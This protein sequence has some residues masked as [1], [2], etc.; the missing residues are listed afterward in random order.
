MSLIHNVRAQYTQSTRFPVIAGLENAIWIPFKN[1]TF[2]L[3][4]PWPL[5][6]T[7]L[8]LNH[9][10]LLL[11]KLGWIADFYVGRSAKKRKTRERSRAESTE[12]EAG[13]AIQIPGSMG[14]QGIEFQVAPDGKEQSQGCF[15]VWTNYEFLSIGVYTTC[16]T[17][18]E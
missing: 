11:Q 17:G 16:D 12:K 8:S 1:R 9:G 10:I 14:G 3:Y 5:Q 13:Q 7:K 2:Y 6:E 4:L 15:C 18:R